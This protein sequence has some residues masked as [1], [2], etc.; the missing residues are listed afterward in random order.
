MQS[1][2]IVF[3]GC[4]YYGR[5]DSMCILHPPLVISAHFHCLLIL[6]PSALPV[7]LSLLNE[8]SRQWCVRAV[9]HWN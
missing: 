9:H 3:V 4:A 1:A 7:F 6:H 5:R 8:P 2:L